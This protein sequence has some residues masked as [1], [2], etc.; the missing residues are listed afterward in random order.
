MQRL[1]PHTAPPGQSALE[2]H[3]SAACVAQ[4][5]HRHC[6]VVN[7]GAVQNGL[8]AVMPRET[9]PVVLLRLIGRLAITPPESGG[10]SRLV[11]PKKTFADAPLMSQ[12]WPFRCPPEHVPPR[13]PSFDVGSP[14]HLG[15]GSSAVGPE[16]TCEM[17]WIVAAPEPASTFTVPL[18]G[19]TTRLPTHVE[20]P[21]AA[22]GR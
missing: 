8:P 4:V 13:L 10:Q 2:A 20:T 17:S 7:P 12:A 6:S 9:E 15:Q 14:V 22:S 21:P 5:S 19:P 16:K 3:G 18:T 1:P 11:A